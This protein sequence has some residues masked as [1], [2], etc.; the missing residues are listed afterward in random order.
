M[1]ELKLANGFIVWKNTSDLYDSQEEA[2][3]ATIARME[4]NI[5]ESLKVLNSL[6]KYGYNCRF[7]LDIKE[8]DKP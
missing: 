5:L 3:K 6:R 8:G 4:S 2:V 7:N 1:R